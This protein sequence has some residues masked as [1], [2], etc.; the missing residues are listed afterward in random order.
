VLL[1]RLYNRA[2][3]A[4]PELTALVSRSLGNSDDWP[5]IAS[6]AAL[7]DEAASLGVS[8]PATTVIDDADALA[9]WAAAQ[10]LPVVLKTDGSWGGRGVA[11]IRDSADL[12]RAWSTISKPPGLTRAVKR[13]LFDSDDSSLSRSLRRIRPVVNAQ[14]FV[15]GREAIATVACVDGEVLAIVCLEVVQV[16]EAKGPAAVVRVIDH[17][18]MEQAAHQIVGH[19]RLTG[20]CGFDFMLTSGGARLLELNPRVTPTCHLLVEG[21]YPRGR[22]ITLFPADPALSAEHRTEPSELDVPRRAPRLVR[23]GETMIAR[24]NRPVSR[25]ASRLTKKFSPFP[26]LY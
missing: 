26:L 11:V 12:Q 8:A 13:A 19:F 7:I 20:F 10:S 18:A 21:T 2:R 3:T 1:R 16:T 23:A 24:K 22:A 14:Q 9:A 5:F 25:I 4:D 15:N 17:P 6:R